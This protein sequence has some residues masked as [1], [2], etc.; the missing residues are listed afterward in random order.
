MPV[1]LAVIRRAGIAVSVAVLVPVSAAAMAGPVPGWRTV[2][3]TARQGTFYALTAADQRHAWAVGASF[4]AA[5]SEFVPLIGRWNG[6]AWAAVGLPGTVRS[7]LG[8]LALLDTAAAS[9]PR[10]M[11][12]F[13]F[14]GGWLHYDGSRWIAGIVPDVLVITASTVA[15]RKYAWSFGLRD[16][17]H[18]P[19][20]Y[21]AY[22]ADVK[23]QVRWT[24]KAIPGGTVVYGAS[25]VSGSDLWAAGI[26]GP[27][28]SPGSRAG[29]G[30]GAREVTAAL[31]GI[32]GSVSGKGAALRS[33]VLHYYAGRWHKAVPLPAAM[34]KNPATAIFARSDTDVWVGGAV[35]NAA[36][37]TTEAVAHW[38]GRA[39]ALVKLPARASKTDYRVYA[40]TTD[41]SAGLWVLAAWAAC[42]G[43]NCAHGRAS[44]LWHEQAGHWSGPVRPALT[45]HPAV[46]LS[47]AA[48][49][50]MVW[51]AGAA[52]L[53]EHNVRGLVAAWRQTRR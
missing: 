30:A 5:S 12:A 1:R 43:T 13:S 39:W 22:A 10:S 14:T 25:A 4:D 32:A 38:N 2:D 53:G 48:A 19:V 20:P 18:N 51:A 33:G 7:V 8:P 24:D 27:V 36:G 23:G 45:R 37:G 40:I 28:L 6:A 46:L 29:R 50:R 16:T 26:G 3:V 44:R 42:P 47:L 52:M 49:G 21:S 34:R 35:R 17:F 31:D 41:G 9:G 15:A 11:W